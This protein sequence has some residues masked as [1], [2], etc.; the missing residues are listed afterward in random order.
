MIKSRFALM[1]RG[2]VRDVDTNSTSIFNIIE[3]M[4]VVGFPVFVPEISFY[5]YLVREPVDPPTMECI[6]TI[7]LDNKIILETHVKSEFEDQLANRLTIHIAGMPIPSP[8]TLIAELKSKNGEP[9]A[10]Y[11][12]QITYIGKQHVTV[13]SD[14]SPA[15]PLP[16]LEPKKLKGDEKNNDVDDGQPGEDQPENDVPLGK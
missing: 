13:V 5:A 9:V 1:A 4:A 2:I 10:S 15:K 12:V 6:F 16:G 3:N 8:G 11:D 7:R 14:A